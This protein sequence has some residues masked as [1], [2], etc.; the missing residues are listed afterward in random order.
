MNDFDFFTVRA[1]SNSIRALM[2]L[3]NVTRDQIETKQIWA[4]RWPRKEH[5]VFIGSVG[6]MNIGHVAAS[7]RADE[8]GQ[9][10]TDAAV[11]GV[12]PRVQFWP[13]D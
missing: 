1:V 11:P 10:I 13:S 5:S 4:G 3:P 9:T 12:F 8:I 2:K 7:A 6:V